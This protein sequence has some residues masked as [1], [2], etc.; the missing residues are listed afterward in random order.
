MQFYFSNKK[1][2]KIK[3][4]IFQKCVIDVILVFLLLTLN[5]FSIVSTVDFELQMLAGCILNAYYL[6]P[7]GNAPIIL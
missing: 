1:K 7:T 3:K 4:Q 5:I 2:T 6:A